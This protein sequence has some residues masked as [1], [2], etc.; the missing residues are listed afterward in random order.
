[1]LNRE[2]TIVFETGQWWKKNLMVLCWLL[3]VV[4][5]AIEIF[6]YFVSQSWVG[7]GN[8]V[9]LFVLVPVVVY[10]STA[11]SIRCPKCMAHWWLDAVKEN[12][13]NKEYQCYS[14]NQHVH[15]AASQVSQSYNAL[16]SDLA[17]LASRAA[18]GR[19]AQR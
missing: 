11:Y 10:F 19:L 18:F 4:P 7:L 17:L 16:Q 14:N 2:D 5:V 3:A 8:E 13:G 15:H 12:V 1:M 6:G 9:M